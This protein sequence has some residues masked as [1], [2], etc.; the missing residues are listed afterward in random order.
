MITEDN[1]C[2]FVYYT[3]IAKTVDR[4]VY[5]AH[6]YNSWVCGANENSSRLL[7]QYTPKKHGFEMRYRRK[8]ELC[9]ETNKQSFK[10][11]FRVQTTKHG[12]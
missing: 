1:D 10:E 7:R 8:H 9:Y 5:F 11:V 3:E 6:P 2:E 12:F 4:K